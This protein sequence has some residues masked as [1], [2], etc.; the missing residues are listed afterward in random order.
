MSEFTRY[1]LEARSL[2]GCRIRLKFHYQELL[3]E[4][5]PIVRANIA[6]ALAEAV[7]DLAELEGKTFLPSIRMGRIYRKFLATNSYSSI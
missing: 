2:Q 3:Q 5:D 6:R 7:L 4:T 1:A